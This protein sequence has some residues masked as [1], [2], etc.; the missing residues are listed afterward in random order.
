MAIRTIRTPVTSVKVH[1]PTI[2]SHKRRALETSLT[3]PKDAIRIHVLANGFVENLVARAFVYLEVNALDASVSIL[4]YGST[5]PAPAI[6]YR[7]L[8]TGDKQQGQTLGHALRPL[9]RNG[10]F[11]KGC[12]RG[13]CTHAK[14]LTTARVGNVLIDHSL[15][16]RKP[17][18]RRARIL[19]RL[20]IG[21]CT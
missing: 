9:A 4:F 10:L 7:V 6:A 21:A 1:P 14:H 17:I 5:Y 15:I 3:Q 2:R 11:N 16:S 20:A 12:Q 8:G 13:I 18:K 19:N